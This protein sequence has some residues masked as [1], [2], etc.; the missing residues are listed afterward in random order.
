MSFKKEIIFIIFLGLLTCFGCE[1]T[2]SLARG[3]AEV[4]R[5]VTQGAGKDLA[6]AG[7]AIMKFD[8]WI[9]ENLW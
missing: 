9:K 4:G 1:T 7:S 6:S 8:E 3:T 2:S 5:S